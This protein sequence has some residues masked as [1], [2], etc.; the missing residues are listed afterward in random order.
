VVLPECCPP[1]VHELLNTPVEN[2]QVEYARL[3][4]T[5]PK[6]AHELHARRRQERQ[7]IS[8]VTENHVR[9]KFGHK[10]IGKAWVQETALFQIV[11]RLYP[12]REVVHHYRADFLQGLE[13]D[14]F[15]PELKLGLEYQGVQH[16][17]PVE[18]WGGSEGLDELRERD[19]LKARLCR[20][21]GVALVHVRYDDPLNEEHVAG[22]IE[23]ARLALRRRLAG[24]Q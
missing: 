9:E 23:Q 10:P 12:E 15:V 21:A 14:V 20:R 6:A 16:F 17:E 5:D 4:E 3:L 13:L 1:E 24:K 18:H 7:S 2:Y 22:K 11:Q 8:Q 19:K